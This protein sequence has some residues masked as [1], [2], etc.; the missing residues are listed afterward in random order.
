MALI[1]S[2]IKIKLLKPKD[3]TQNYLKWFK[4]QEVKKYVI[5]TR[6]KNINE[7]K[8]Y[9]QNNFR[10]K[11][12]V[13][14]GIFLKNKHIGNLKFEKINIKNKT[15]VMGILIGE[16]KYRNRGYSTNAINI[17]IQYV[18][19]KYHINSFILGVNKK[20]ILAINAYKKTGF[21][22]FDEKKNSFLMRNNLNLLNLSNF[23]LG[24]AQFG[25]K[26]GINNQV[27]KLKI[28]QI[29]KIIYHANILGIRSIDTAISY[30]SAEKILGKVGVKNFKITSKLPYIK[31]H[32]VDE[33]EKLVKKTLF[34]LNIN[35]LE[36]LL[37]HSSK[38]LNKNTENILKAMRKLK[39]K[40]FVKFIGISITNFADIW[41]I[42]KNHKIDVVQVP[43]N[44]LDRRIENKKLV[45]LLKKKNIKVQVR[46]IFLQGLLF[47]KYSEIP[48]KLR[49]KSKHLKKIKNF[50]TNSKKNKL[51]TMLNF[52]YKNKTVKHFIL[53]VDNYKQL[54]EIAKV[55][56]SNKIN[57]NGLRCNDE[58]LINPSKWRI[59]EK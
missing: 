40:K 7:L 15:S 8:N 54:S 13:F 24:S 59:N 25:L 28:N 10:K 51:N 44:I 26:Y 33:V 47:K 21:R 23:S 18:S 48:T 20:N 11:N 6:Y 49:R 34:N 39:S 32:K 56:I 36:C 3:V 53:G 46:S 1:K 17:C 27:G 35:Q 43:Y 37:I 42:L 2:K 57:Y 9:V 55:K 16:K 12:C 5:N 50:L 58:N 19:R 41:K 29:K 38:N 14:L 52:I 30:G 31:N 22:I 4:D 45:K